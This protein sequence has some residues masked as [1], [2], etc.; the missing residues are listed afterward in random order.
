MTVAVLVSVMVTVGLLVALT[1][2]GGADVTGGRPGTSTPGTAMPGT[3]LSITLL[4]RQPPG[5]LARHACVDLPLIDPAGLSRA[6]REGRA[7]AV[8]GK[9]AMT[10]PRAPFGVTA[11]GEVLERCPECDP[12]LEAAGS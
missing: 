10:D 6:Q 11:A 3:A 5:P 2:A 12:A 1:G 7:C 9:A 4:I 8:C